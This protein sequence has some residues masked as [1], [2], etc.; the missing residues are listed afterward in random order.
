MYGEYRRR[1]YNKYNFVDFLIVMFRSVK[2]S[3][4]EKQIIHFKDV[5]F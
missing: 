2:H 4:E 5:G 3:S 1:K